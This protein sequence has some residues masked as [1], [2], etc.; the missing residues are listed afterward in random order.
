MIPVIE[1][2][3]LVLRAM[4][5][6]DFPNFAAIWAEPQTVRYMGG[7][8]YGEN[9]S[10]TS[11]LRNAGTWVVEGFGHW[12]IF[13]KT[14]EVLLGHTGFFTARRGLGADFDADPEAG[15]VLQPAAQ[16]QGFAREAVAAAHAWLDRQGIAATTWAMID[17]GN[18][19]SLGLAA[20]QGYVAQREAEYLGDRV[21]LLARSRFA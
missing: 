19:V 12:G 9:D 2:E 8:V 11:F 1:T 16:G 18:D 13:R 20:K 3:R 14:D 4:L 17:V 10:W 6:A 7:R 5:R 15:W 21:M